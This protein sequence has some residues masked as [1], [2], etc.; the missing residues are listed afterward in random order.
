MKRFINLFHALDKLGGQGGTHLGLLEVGTGEGVR[1]AQLLNY[2]LAA[3]Q[4]SASYRGF[5][6][7]EQLTPDVARED[8]VK[9]PERL[10]QRQEVLRRLSRTGAGVTLYQGNTRETLPAFA[11]ECQKS[12]M[13]FNL[14]FI[15]GGA[16]FDTITSDWKAVSKLVR[17]DTIVLFDGYYDNRDDLGCWSVIQYLALGKAFR[18]FK[19]DPV[20]YIHDSGLEVRMVWVER[21]AHALLETKNR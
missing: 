15:D 12:G 1:A 18:V 5:D 17:P 21:A 8:G 6:L 16:S 9:M 19:L 13:L 11:A 3:G 4:R 20:D 10:P 14:I 7:W 2:W